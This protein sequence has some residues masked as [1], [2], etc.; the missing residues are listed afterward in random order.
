MREIENYFTSPG[1]V[2]PCQFTGVIALANAFIRTIKLKTIQRSINSNPR[3]LT[4]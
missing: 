3:I 2:T 4:I 1:Q